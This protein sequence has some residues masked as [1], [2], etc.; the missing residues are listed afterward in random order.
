MRRQSLAQLAIAF[1]LACAGAPVQA[2][3]R[4]DAEAELVQ[5][6]NAFRAGHEEDGIA[7]VRTA[8]KTDP[9][10]ALPYAI[11]A[12]FLLSQGDGYGGETAARRALE[13]GMRAEQVN[14]LIAYAFYL[15]GDANKALDLAQGKKVS[16]RYAGYAARVRALALAKL[17]DLEGA[18][19]EF[20]LAAQLSPQSAALWSD[21][22][23]F[24]VTVG[25]LS[26]AIDATARSIEINPRRVEALKLMGV[27]VRGQYGLTASLPW[28][29]RAVE[30][31]PG[32][33]DLLRE[34]AA[35]L[36]DAGQTIEMLETTRKMLTLDPANA[37]AFFLQAVLAARAKN[38][39]LARTLL[40]RTQGKIDKVPAVMLLTAA[41]ELQS[42]AAEQAIARL[43][44]I[45]NE[46]PG[47]L[48]AQRLLG[49]ALWK[50]GDSKSTIAALQRIA[51]RSDA[52]SYTLSVIG[53]AY[54]AEGK[55]SSAA[56]YL[57]RAAQPVRGD[58]VP[59]EMAG[60]LNRLAKAS[61]GPSNNAEFAVPYINRLV[62]AGRAGEALG[63][64][65]R[66]R[67]LNPGA[68]A[69][70]VL[71]G[72]SLM[73]L[74]RAPEAVIAYKDAAG[75]RFNEPIALRLIDAL[76]RAGNQAEALRVLDL[77][78]SQNP[79]S[80]PGL[81]LAADHFMVSGQWDR[82]VSVL[83]SLRFRLGNRDA[84]VLNS[85]GWAW[86]NKGNPAKAAEYSGAAYGMVPSNPAFADSYGWILFKTGS[87]KEGGAALLEK[88]VAT[89][90][91][92]PG[93]RYHLGQAL[94]GLGRKDEAK[95]HLRMAASEPDFP[96]AKAAAKLLAGL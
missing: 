7:Q 53:R 17:G 55:R 30:K 36:G 44:D 19:R 66:L 63:H 71:V 88:A 4:T 68:P 59:F 78:L 22:G 15:Q 76:G 5:G 85:L 94:A 41:L 79:R 27:L 73:A 75:I 77:F 51:N 52:D 11:R 95:V 57:D 56:T 90:P 32:N 16:P 9:K 69:A 72:D 39:D 14:Q 33:L 87:N 13:L 65:Q 84:T 31:A 45:V 2:S 12:S 21:I 24:R 43:E 18:G 92:H 42:G 96:D 83:E 91:K 6:V 3:D 50:A 54:E 28:F 89:A 48:K 74:G 49:A 1:G 64:A 35:T 80:V 93:L 20:D 34:F 61:V 86:F 62:L 37:D 10:W 67:A 46:Q 25:N 47:N 70:H 38:Y 29:R 81:L 58:A 60:D 26:G 82:A 23:N 8:S 40:Y